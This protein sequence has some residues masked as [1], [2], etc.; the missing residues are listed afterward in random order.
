MKNT[1]LI[2]LVLLL[3]SCKMKKK[4]TK[5]VSEQ[6]T[7]DNSEL[8][9]IYR[10]DQSDRQTDNIDWNIVSKNDSLREELKILQNKNI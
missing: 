10:N 4:N 2:I 5:T 1:L 3:A 9:E 6:K 7:T 8:I